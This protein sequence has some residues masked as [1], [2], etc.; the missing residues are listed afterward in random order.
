MLSDVYMIIVTAFA[1]FGFYCLAEQV[2]TAIKYS[3]TPKTITIIK[4]DASYRTYDAI[5]YI[6]NTLYNN[7]TVVISDNPDN[8][9]P[10]ATTVRPGELS[11]Y[12]TN[13]LFTKPHN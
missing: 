8:K 2:I 9:C 7:E 1:L 6:H 10:L 5:Q 11:Q 3:D 4:Y 13:A 12:I